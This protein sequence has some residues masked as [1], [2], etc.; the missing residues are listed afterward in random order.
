LVK[1]SRDGFQKFFPKWSDF[2]RKDEFEGERNLTQTIERD[3]RKFVHFLN[4]DEPDFQ[5]F[6]W[7]K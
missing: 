4:G 3:V 7:K 2:L 6:S 5:P 1:L